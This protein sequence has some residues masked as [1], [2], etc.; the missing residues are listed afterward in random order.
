MQGNDL[1]IARVAKAAKVGVETVRF[2]ERRGLI[3]Q[4]AK[5][6][7]AYR[8]YDAEHV[9]RIRF[10][11]RSQELGFTL[12]EIE[13]LLRLED[14]ADRRSVQ[15]IA[16]ARLEQVRE[17]IADLRRIERTLSHLLEDCRNGAGHRCPIISAIAPDQA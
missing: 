6:N 2:Y 1:T 7:G 12:E 13:S 8:R 16:T 10:V 15:K 14:G 17:R 3:A 9:R 4:P 5:M 11:K